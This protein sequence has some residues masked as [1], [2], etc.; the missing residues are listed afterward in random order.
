MKREARGGRL[1]EHVKA[2]I[3]ELIGSNRYPVGERLPSE[4][5]LAQMFEVSRP[6]V[7]EAIIALEL[8]GQVE[9]RNG[10]GVV[11]TA[12]RPAG[13]KAS[14]MD[15]GPFELLEARRAIEGEVCAL[16][17]KNGT[18][19]H[20]HRLDELLHEIRTAENFET[21]EEADRK[22][23]VEIAR[24]TRNSAMVDIVEQLWEARARSPQYRLLSAKAHAAGLGPRVPEHKPIIT[25]LRARDAEGA[26][27]AMRDHLNSVLRTLLEATE[28]HEI[29]EAQA[30]II[31]T[32]R[33]F[34]EV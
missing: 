10:Y 17:A 6:T 8:D 30:R 26:R 32:R 5:N 19:E 33:R 25:A 16:A 14:A 3:A 13:G 1:Y 9:V 12:T 4:R 2:K 23:H 34:A 15:V 7:R 20:F 29:E 31:A 18:N 21:A 22:F 27:S 24:A 11:V 28:V